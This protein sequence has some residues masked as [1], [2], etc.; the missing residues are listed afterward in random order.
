MRKR[1]LPALIALALLA[2]APAA[3]QRA[4]IQDRLL[5]AL[6]TAVKEHEIFLNCSA[7]DR[8]AH[9]L[10]RRGW[11]DMVREAIAALEAAKADD[12]VLKQYRERTDAEKMLKRDARFADILEFCSGDWMERAIS[13]KYLM[14][15]V[16]VKEILEAK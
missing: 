4:G 5:A 15:N 2:A 6:D 7:T 16:R 11:D 9:T 1:A 10:I 13:L 3:A 14:L 12:A 8:P